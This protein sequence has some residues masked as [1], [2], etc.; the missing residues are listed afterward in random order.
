MVQIARDYK[1]GFVELRAANP[2]LDPWIP[3]EGK[4]VAIP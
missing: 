4:K 1:M 3:G 2:F